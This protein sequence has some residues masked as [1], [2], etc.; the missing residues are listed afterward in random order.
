ME[1]L[2]AAMESTHVSQQMQVSIRRMETRMDIGVA[3]NTV[4]AVL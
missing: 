1:F 3:S 4:M 2:F